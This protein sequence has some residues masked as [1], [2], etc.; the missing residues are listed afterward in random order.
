M[1]K[2]RVLECNEH[3]RGRGEGFL[4]W[5]RITGY[6]SSLNQFNNAKRK[7]VKDRVKHTNKSGEEK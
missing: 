3:D 6:V 1:D 7:E 2:E 5:R 4:R